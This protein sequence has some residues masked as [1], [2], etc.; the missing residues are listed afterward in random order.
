MNKIL[1]WLKLHWKYLKYET[2]LL[3]FIVYMETFHQTI[4]SS[5]LYFLFLNAGET[6]ITNIVKNP[7][8]SD[9]IITAIAAIPYVKKLLQNKNNK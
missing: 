7:L 1:E 4:L 3:I 5:F 6:L 8:L 9:I 2:L